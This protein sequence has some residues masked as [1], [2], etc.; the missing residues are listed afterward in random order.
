MKKMI[1]VPECDRPREKIRRLG[2]AALSDQELI[3][4]I[5]GRGVRGSDVFSVAGELAK[6][7]RGGREGLTYEKMEA[8]HGM[9]PAKAA[10][11]SACFELS[12]RYPEKDPGHVLRVTRPEDVITLLNGLEFKKQEHFI[13][14]TLNGA[15]EVLG[16][17][18]ITV[19]LLNHSLVHPRE[20]FADAIT[21]RA[22]SIVCVHNHPSGTLEPSLQDLEVTR[23]LTEAGGILGIRV[24]DHLIV[25]KNGFLS[26]K[27]QGLL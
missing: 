20:V 22:A 6:E 25:T 14:I 1:H 5:I 10:Q 3:A 13:C 7:L 23:Q 12:R 17:R 27:E 26:M 18:I 16:N 24:I 19:G 8:V 4:A 15:G 9:G 21:D 2:P 11:M